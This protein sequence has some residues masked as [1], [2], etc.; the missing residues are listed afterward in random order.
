M[1]GN[2][3]NFIA[4]STLSPSLKAMVVYFYINYVKPFD[5]YS[6]E[7]AVLMAKAVLATS[8]GEVIVDFPFEKLLLLA[9]EEIARVYVEVQKQPM[10]PIL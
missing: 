2:M 8:F 7:I 3:F 9:K 5:R 4:T 10:L 1:M 6:D